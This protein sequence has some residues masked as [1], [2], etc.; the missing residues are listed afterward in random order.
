[1]EEEKITLADK[2]IFGI[3]AF[4]FLYFGGRV[5]IHLLFN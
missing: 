4:G 3:I 1:M 5:I 2:V